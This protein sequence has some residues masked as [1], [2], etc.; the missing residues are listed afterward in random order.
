MRRAWQSL[1]NHLPPLQHI[2][3]V[4]RLRSWPIPSREPTSEPLPPQIPLSLPA[5]P[6]AS[7]LSSAH[8]IAWTSPSLNARQSPQSPLLLSVA[9]GGSMATRSRGHSPARYVSQRRRPQRAVNAPWEAPPPKTFPPPERLGKRLR[10]RRPIL[11]QWGT[12]RQGVHLDQPSTGVIRR[13]RC[14]NCMQR[15]SINDLAVRQ[16]DREK[17]EASG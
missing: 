15:G 10:F 17:G 7:S 11:L 3:V 6:W 14:L 16:G 8:R 12:C 2:P 4:T 5:T 1:T 9:G 13:R